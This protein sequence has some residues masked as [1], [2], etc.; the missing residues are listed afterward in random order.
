MK[1]SKAFLKTASAQK[2]VKIERI[3]NVPKFL[4]Y[5]AVRKGKNGVGERYLFHGTNRD[6]I[7]SINH[8]GWNR[9]YAG[10]N[11]KLNELEYWKS[12][13]VFFVMKPQYNLDCIWRR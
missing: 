3:Q 13:S 11:G 10:T 9:S 8:D 5:T 6:N 2:I 12:L 1:V 4:L 7:D